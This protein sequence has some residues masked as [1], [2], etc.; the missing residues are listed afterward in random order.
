MSN[1]KS[2]LAV[3]TVL[4]VLSAA[5]QAFATNAKTFVSNTGTDTGGCPKTAPCATFAFALGQTTAGGEISV[6]NRGEY[7]P[8]SITQ[9]VSI[10]AEGAEGGITALSGYSGITVY[11]PGGT[12]RLRGLTIDGAANGGDSGIYVSAGSVDLENCVLRGFSNS[13]VYF[14]ILDSAS[15]H[16]ADVL[17]TDSNYGI[18]LAPGGS[19]VTYADLTRVRTDG[20][21]QGVRADGTGGVTGQLQVQVKDS[22]F[23]NGTWGVLAYSSTAPLVVVSLSNT[24]S[25]GNQVG[26]MSNGPQSVIILDRTT[27]QAN[28]VQALNT[29]N[30][31]VIYSYGN[32]SINDNAALG[33]SPT[34][35]GLH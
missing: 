27:I 18:F 16:V 9:S 3:F 32:N 20:V 1:C 35:I 22:V 33:T 13:A 11:A 26:V 10:V 21:G 29:T 7:G 17:I 4:F 34:V 28:T 6:L 12:V 14:Q 15:L 19:A 5:P 31:G 23:A 8:V 2:S 30:G 24:H 25:V